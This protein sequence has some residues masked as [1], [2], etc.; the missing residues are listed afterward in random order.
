MSYEVIQLAETA[1]VN[2]RVFFSLVSGS[3]GITPVVA[4]TGKLY[5]SKNGATPFTSSA[6]ITQIDSTN[7]PGRYYLQL[8]TTEIDNI[9]QLLYR[10]S[11]SSSA[12][13]IGQASIVN[14]S[15]FNTS[16][17]STGSFSADIWSYATR[18]LTQQVTASVDTASVAAGVWLY[19]TRTLT[20]LNTASISESVWAAPTRTLTN[21]NTASISAS[22]WA[23]PTRTLTNL[24]TASISAS[25]WSHPTRT[26]TNLDTASISA[27]V[28]AAPTRSLTTQVTA[29]VDTASIS[30]GVWSYTA[31]TL[32]NLDTSSIWTAPSRTLTNLD[33]ASISA[34][35]WATP[36]RSLTTT[37]SADT[38]S[39]STAVWTHTTRT[40]TNLD[41]ASVWLAPT[42]SL[43]LP[44]TSSIDSSSIVSVVDAVW[45]E[46]RSTHITAGSFG[47]GVPVI[48]IDDSVATKIGNFTLDISNA[49][50]TGSSLRQMVRLIAAATLGVSNGAGTTTIT[51]RNAVADTKVRITGTV[52]PTTG[53]RSVVIT[54]AT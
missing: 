48:S 21:L 41:T 39:I 3:N 25:V 44:V 43:T 15:P 30:L 19:T 6:S 18:S 7:M 26:L 51:F 23:H 46:P 54:D 34:S 32:T 22:V 10:Y 4:A 17:I 47:E 13:M 2:R 20:N 1:S 53:E 42:R 14:Y 45:N 24:D 16:S 8:D 38:A 28:W 37:P 29:S 36:T 31:R 11:V 52:N 35:V 50:E 12:E 27:S 33:T 40:L 49:I 9:G 5:L